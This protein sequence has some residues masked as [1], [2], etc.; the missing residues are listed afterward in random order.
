MALALTY[1]MFS[2]FTRDAGKSPRNFNEN[3]ESEK[4]RTQRDGSGG[5]AAH[6]SPP[7]LSIRLCNLFF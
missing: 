5:N 1:A 6:S 4:E 2:N 7:T 3:V